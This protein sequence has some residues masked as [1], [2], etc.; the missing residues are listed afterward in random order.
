M[1][2]FHVKMNIAFQRML[3]R[4]RPE[5]SQK[6]PQIPFFNDGEVEGLR[7]EERLSYCVPE[8]YTFVRCRL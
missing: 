1:R 8:V 2:I 4:E 5:E 7:N 6:I 3:E